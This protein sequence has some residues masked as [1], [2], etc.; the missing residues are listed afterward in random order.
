MMITPISMAGEQRPYGCPACPAT[1]GDRLLLGQRAGEG[2]HEDHPARTGR[3]ASPRRRPVLY[4]SVLVLSPA[5]ADP[6]L[7]AMDVKA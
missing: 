4:Q 5:N 6:L 1:R 2:Q 3:R 7:L